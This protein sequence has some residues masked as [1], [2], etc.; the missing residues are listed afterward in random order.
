M[1]FKALEQAERDNV[2]QESPPAPQATAQAV[3]ETVSERPPVI[4]P[5]A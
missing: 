3:A 1:F 4:A 2:E 5:L